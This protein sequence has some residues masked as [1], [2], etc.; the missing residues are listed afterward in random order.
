MMHPVERRYEEWDRDLTL[1]RDAAREM[2]M[3]EMRLR[4]QVGVA[5]RN[6]H[7]WP[8]IGVVLG[9]SEQDAQDR[10]GWPDDDASP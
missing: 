10:F 4:H 1:V 5:R 2:S 9:I 3:A 8:A 7:S 6:G